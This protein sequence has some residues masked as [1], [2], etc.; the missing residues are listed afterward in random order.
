MPR[1]V[2]RLPRLKGSTIGAWCC[3]FSSRLTIAAPYVLVCGLGLLA[4][5]AEA[6]AD[7]FLLKSGACVRGEWLNS[8]ESPIKRYVVRWESGGQLTLDRKQVAQHLREANAV[9]EYDREVPVRPDTVADHLRTAEWCRT[10]GLADQERQ[11]LQRIL[12]LDSDHQVARR[13]LGFTEID[14]KWVTTQEFF[15]ERGFVYYRGKW[16]LPQDVELME[17]RRQVERQDREWLARLKTWRGQLGTERDAEAV[18]HFKAIHEPVALHALSDYLRREKSQRVRLLLVTAIANIRSPHAVRLLTQTALDDGDIEIFHVCV[19]KLVAIQSPGLSR[20]VTEF[21]RDTNNR[22]VNRAAYLL[23]Q[24]GDRQVIPALAAALVTTHQVALPTSTGT[25]ATF[26][27]PA[28][29]SNGATGLEGSLG[30]SSGREPQASVVR[31]P[32]QEVLTALVKL[33]G[34]QSYGFEERA[35]MNWWASVTFPTPAGLT[36]R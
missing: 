26:F 5:G 34:G 29:N 24:L 25:T 28:A 36:G 32:N 21:L 14:G 9:W 33:S 16:R 4:C 7:T 22:R 23:G 12:E 8:D 11:H 2:D 10:H 17:E 3:A 31:V 20:A 35:W 6:N 1:A 13:R 18:R 30:F 27:R 19:D 15:R